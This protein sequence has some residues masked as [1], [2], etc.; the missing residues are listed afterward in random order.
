MLRLSNDDGLA[1]DI[2][3]D[4]PGLIRRSKAGARPIAAP[5]SQRLARAGAILNLLSALPEEQVPP[6]LVDLTLHRID[7]RPVSS[8]LASAP[9]PQ[10]RPHA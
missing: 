9:R 4:T 3:L 5:Y 10:F 8:S 7:A 6:D 1:V 2:L